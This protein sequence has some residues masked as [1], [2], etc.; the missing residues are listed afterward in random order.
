MWLGKDPLMM[1]RAPPAV[2]SRESFLRGKLFLSSMPQ[3]HNEVDAS[4]LE[5]ATFSGGLAASLGRFLQTVH[6]RSLSNTRTTELL[7]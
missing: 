6:P 5:V 2:T 1:I 7:R 3:G 4:F